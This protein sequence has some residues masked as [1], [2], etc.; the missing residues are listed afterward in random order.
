MI[1][2]LTLIAAVLAFALIIRIEYKTAAAAVT[3][4]MAY[5]TF[6]VLAATALLVYSQDRGGA[7]PRLETSQEAKQFLEYELSIPP[8]LVPLDDESFASWSARKQDSLRANQALKEAFPALVDSDEIYKRHQE[9]YNYEWT[10]TRVVLS[11]L[12]QIALVIIGLV[13]LFPLIM[14][15]FSRLVAP[16]LSR[17]KQTRIVYN[18]SKIK[19]DSGTA[20]SACIPR[21][22]SPLF[23]SHFCFVYYQGFILIAEGGSDPIIPL[24]SIESETPS[25][26]FI[27][28]YKRGEKVRVH[29]VPKAW[30]QPLLITDPMTWLVVKKKAGLQA[31]KLSE[32]PLDLANPAWSRVTKV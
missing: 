14:L 7:P 11:T 28:L 4:T 30:L 17:K 3:F 2:A 13:F 25:G 9:A 20:I 8:Q 10:R 19:S 29:E 1:I 26:D 21:L 27:V 22:W 5:I 6:L 23:W 16:L 18:L 32:V 31:P 15:G 24:L 12:D